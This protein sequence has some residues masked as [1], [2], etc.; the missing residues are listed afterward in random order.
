MKKNVSALLILLL[1]LTS[2]LNI[3]AKTID[4]TFI[5]YGYTEDGLSYQVYGATLYVSDNSINVTS[6][7]VYD[8]YIIPESSLV[9]TEVIDNEKYSG[10]LY[11]VSMS[12]N[13][14][15]NQTTVTYEGTLTKQ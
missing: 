13:A 14:S 10:T 2:P 8:G 4:N 6:T 12:Y 9:W 15:T 5:Q 11:W 3:S 1:V 7:I